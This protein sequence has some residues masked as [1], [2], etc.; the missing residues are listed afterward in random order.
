MTCTHALAVN[1]TAYDRLLADIPGPDGIEEWITVH[2]AIDQFL[3]RQ[4]NAGRYRAYVVNPR[5][6]TQIELTGPAG[7]D[8][9]L[10]DRYTIR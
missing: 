1:H 8:G 5:V 6:S 10:R 4:V 9:A 2:I 3:G 7:L